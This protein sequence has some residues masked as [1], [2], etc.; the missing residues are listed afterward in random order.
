MKTQPPPTPDDL[1]RQP[2]EFNEAWRQFTGRVTPE[3]L[4]GPLHSNGMYQMAEHEFITKEA[5][6]EAIKEFVERQGQ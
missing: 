3:S 4:F 2:R 6:E 5:A 1:E